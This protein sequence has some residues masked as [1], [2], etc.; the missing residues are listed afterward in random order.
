MIYFLK[1]HWPLAGIVL[2]VALAAFYLLKAGWDANSRTI[3]KEV[4]G[5]SDLRLKDVHYSHEDPDTKMKW[6]LDAQQVNFTADKSLVTFDDFHI[7][8]SPQD[9][10]WIR[11][12]GQEGR[13]V[14]ELG[15]IDLNGD[16]RGV[17]E[18]G[19]RFSGDHVTV[20]EKRRQITTDG[21]VKI[22][23]PFF[24][25]EGRGL[26]VDLEDEKFKILDEVTTVI[27]REEAFDL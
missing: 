14:K 10:P 18:N 19:Y 17:S 23:G 6:V 7:R 12:K 5:R 20:D 2:V 13:Y 1:R 26:F 9:R 24:T 22:Y 25:I 15:S 4:V 21:P 8:L 11:L 16:L 3:I 27:A